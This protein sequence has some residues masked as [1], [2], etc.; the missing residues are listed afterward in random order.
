MLNYLSAI[1]TKKYLNA[2]AEKEQT[3]VDV[4]YSA[5]LQETKN[6]ANAVKREIRK[7]K[8]VRSDDSAQ[9]KAV[10]SKN[11]GSYFAKAGAEI[12]TSRNMR[13]WYEERH[14]HL[15]LVYKDQIIGNIMLYVEPERDYLV[16]RGFNPRMDAMAK[17]DRYSMASEITR[18][19]EEIA[20]ENGYK[21]VFV[22]EQTSWHALSNRDGMAKE[23]E[24]LSRRNIAK[25]LSEPGNHRTTIEDSEFYVT[26][27]GGT[28]IPK[29]NLLV[30]V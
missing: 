23:I 16:A 21:E 26:E 13:M 12:C 17:F 7:V 9:V 14:L 24:D 30:H 11:V 10:V 3:Y 19:L 1:R 15:N 22:P 5:M 28:S 4:L 20:R 18:V 6:A 2:G 8:S 27:K 25:L 29:L